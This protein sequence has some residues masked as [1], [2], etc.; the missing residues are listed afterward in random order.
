MIKD[1]K[2]FKYDLADKMWLPRYVCEAVSRR[3]S[4]MASAGV[5]ALLKKM[6]YKVRIWGLGH[7]KDYK[8]KHLLRTWWSPSMGLFSDSTPISRMWCSQESLKWWGSTSSLIFS[9]RRWAECWCFHHI[10]DIKDLPIDQFV[11]NSSSVFQDGSGR[12]AA[13]VAAVL[14]GKRED[15][16]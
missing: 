5:T 6:D 14:K 8:T 9:F 15:W 10:K 16:L 13:L 3:A 4:M 7:G 1:D 2:K 11:C 12:G